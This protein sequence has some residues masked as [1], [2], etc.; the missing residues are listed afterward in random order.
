MANT[1]PAKS[2]PR[3]KA[4]STVGSGKNSSTKQGFSDSE[5]KMQIGVAKSS[6]GSGGKPSLDPMT[7]EALK[8][9]GC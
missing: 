5:M 3:T 7:R 8:N 2:S 4:S 1:Q 9:V 6:V